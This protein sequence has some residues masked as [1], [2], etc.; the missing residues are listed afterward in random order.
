MDQD[1][2]SGVIAGYVICNRQEGLAALKERESA[3]RD[4]MQEQEIA[5]SEI[6]FIYSEHADINNFAGKA[7]EINRTGMS[8][9][10]LYETA[11]TFMKTFL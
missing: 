7:D 2:A 11:K 1:S 3:F 8:S 10:K 6:K 5:V 9:A 4:K